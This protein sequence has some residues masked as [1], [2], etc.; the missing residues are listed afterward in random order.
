MATTTDPDR[1]ADLGELI[2]ERRRQMGMD[3]AHLAEAA[4]VSE[5]TI[6]NYERGRVP[7]RG[8]MPAGYWRVE[9]ALKLGKGS[10]ESILAG[11]GVTF[12]IDGPASGRMRLRGP[13]E[14]DDPHLKAVV[15]KVGEALNM[16]GLAMAFADLAHRW[17][18]PEDLLDQYKEALDNLLAGMFQPGSGPPELQRY[19]EA[20]A[21]GLTPESDAMERNPELGWAAYA[22]D[23]AEARPAGMGEELRAARCARGLSRE[24]LSDLTHVPARIISLI[25]SEDFTFAGASMHAPV[26]IKLL[27]EEVGLDAESLIE[28]F[29]R[30]HVE[31]Q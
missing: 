6:G 31:G 21:A 4:G 15:E 17:N 18:A 1:W 25:E 23:P 19:R 28:Q 22:A 20:Q 11:E 5:N 7:A 3:Q 9:K 12:E 14:I 16:S 8:K 29:R 13:D 10:F 26:Y 24:E 2:A 27:A 30:D